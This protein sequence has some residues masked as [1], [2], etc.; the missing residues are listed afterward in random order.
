MKATKRAVVRKDQNTYEIPNTPI[1]LMQ[2]CTPF[3]DGQIGIASRQQY[4]LC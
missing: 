3:S 1:M 4:N 2:C